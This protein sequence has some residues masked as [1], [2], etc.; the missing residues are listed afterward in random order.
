MKTP[1]QI[2]DVKT[3]A[4]DVEIKQAYLRRIKD[5]PPDRD[6]ERFQLIHNAYNSIKDIKSRERYALFTFPI[7]NFDEVIDH[8]LNT[9]QVMELKSEHLIKLLR[10]SIDESTFLN[11][12]P[13]REIQ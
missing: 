11:A 4:G 13:S 12:I 8:A 7:A 1:Y 6:Q 3:D 2:L 10:A 9:G 5:N